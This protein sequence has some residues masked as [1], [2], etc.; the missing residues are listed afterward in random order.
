MSSNLILK[1][2]TI[3]KT[4]NKKTFMKRTKKNEAKI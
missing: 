4:I 1:D 2:E 3:E